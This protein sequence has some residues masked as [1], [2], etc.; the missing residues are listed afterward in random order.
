MKT[1][2]NVFLLTKNISRLIQLCL[3]SVRINSMSVFGCLWMFECFEFWG[4]F[5]LGPWLHRIRNGFIY[6]FCLYDFERILLLVLGINDD[7]F[8]S[9]DANHLFLPL[10]SFFFFFFYS[11]KFTWWQ[12][13]WNGFDFCM[14]NRLFFWNATKHC[15]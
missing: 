10:F 8:D 6:V 15:Q 7:C 2:I 5:E 3:T 13:W 14:R 1:K 12:K 11:I 9:L 4:A